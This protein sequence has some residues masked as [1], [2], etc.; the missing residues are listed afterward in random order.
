MDKLKQL[1]KDTIALDNNVLIYYAVTW[2]SFAIGILI[3]IIVDWRLVIGL[4]LLKFSETLA[5]ALR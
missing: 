4:F 2:I 3:I 1:Y 5:K